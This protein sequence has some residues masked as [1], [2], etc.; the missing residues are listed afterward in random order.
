MLSALFA[1]ALAAVVPIGSARHHHHRSSAVYSGSDDSTPT[2]L[3]TI[4]TPLSSF[5]GSVPTSAIVVASTATT[6][7]AYTAASGNATTVPAAFKWQPKVGQS[8]QI[9]INGLLE[10]PSG[11]IQPDVDV[12]DIDLFGNNKPVVDALHSL[13]KHVICYFSAG[14]P[15]S[16]PR[17]LRCFWTS[18]ASSS[19]ESRAHTQ[20][21]SEW[22]QIIFVEDRDVGCQCVCRRRL[23]QSRTARVAST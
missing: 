10:M 17:N 2:T 3:S 9:A 1:I 6:A 19:R 13:G 12:F 23:C 8:W 16:L 7:P 15:D 20:N 22:D 21:F 4:T 18:P 11:S 14:Y 5:T